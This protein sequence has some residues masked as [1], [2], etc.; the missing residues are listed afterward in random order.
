MSKINLN[1]H[2]SISLLTPF[3]KMD[4]VARLD[5]ANNSFK[6]CVIPTEAEYP[7]VD[8]SYTNDML[9]STDNIVELGGVK[10]LKKIEKVINDVI[11]EV[12]YIYET[13]KDHKVKMVIIPASQSC[14]PFGY[15]MDSVFSKMEVNEIIDKPAHVKYYDFYDPESNIVSFG[16]NVNYI[17]STSKSVGE[18]SIVISE[19][20]AKKFSIRQQETVEIVISPDYILRNLYGNDEIYKPLPLPGDH[21]ND[22][23]LARMY[24]DESKSFLAYDDDRNLDSDIIY[25]VKGKDVKIID[26][27]IYSKNPIPVESIEKSRQEYL[28]YLMNVVQAI[29]DVER[30]YSTK[31]IDHT[32]RNIKN[33]YTCIL[34]SSDLRLGT[35]ELRNNIVIYYT[36]LSISPLTTGCK[37]TNRH[38]GKGTISQI[39]PDDTIVAE[40]GTHIEAMINTTGIFNR[41]NPAQL[42]ERGLNEL[43]VF[44]RKYLNE[45][46][47]TD[48]TKRNA[49]CTWLETANQKKA[50]DFLRKRSA[51]E[52][53]DY[54]KV[55]DMYLTYKPYDDP[56]DDR[57]MNFKVILELTKYT[58]TLYPVK[59]FKIYYNGIPLSDPCYYG[60]AYYLLLSKGP[61]V[62]TSIRGSAGVNAKGNPTKKEKDKKTHETKYGS[63][64]IKQ[65]DGARGVLLN[66]MFKEDKSILKNNTLPFHNYLNAMG[67]GI[68]FNEENNKGD[69]ND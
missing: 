25:A 53:V 47:D 63:T 35:D 2:A 5:M 58:N 6:H 36:T 1:N 51:K 44:V 31:N 69:D 54:Y 62:S 24:M 14:G 18:D 50:S 7:I 19:S 13:I 21:L 52:V 68:C 10:L 20:L 45:S 26:M 39:V 64:A 57:I 48:T 38:G 23:Y 41:E 60:K 61:F 42:Y 4:S 3:A 22:G 32:I 49:I 16:R 37:L 43:W 9:F 28:K 66:S 29:L 15:K 67:I 59:P 11:C 17:Y 46:T 30:H 12:C 65:S 27:E 56:E 34:N 40:D 33:K 8:S 55:N